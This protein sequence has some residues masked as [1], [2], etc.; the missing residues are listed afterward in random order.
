MQRPPLIPIMSMSQRFHQ[1]LG[2]VLPVEY[3]ARPTPACDRESRADRDPERR[4][5]HPPLASAIDVVD[6]V[7][8]TEARVGAHFGAGDA[9]SDTPPV[10]RCGEGAGRCVALAAVIPR[11]ASH[12]TPPVGGVL[13]P[14]KPFAEHPPEQPVVHEELA[15]ASV[16][17]GEAE[18]AAHVDVRRKHERPHHIA[19]HFEQRDKKML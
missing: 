1:R 6:R 19:K 10:C 3:H 5:F 4:L 17:A 15:C 2:L 14:I 11:N 8:S 7:D 12:R 13:L 9:E 16:D 18:S